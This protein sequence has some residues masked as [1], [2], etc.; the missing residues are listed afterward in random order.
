MRLGPTVGWRQHTSSTQST[1]PVKSKGFFFLLRCSSSRYLRNAFERSEM[2]PK[3]KKRAATTSWTSDR[4]VP[5]LSYE[6]IRFVRKLMA[7]AVQC[8]LLWLMGI[9]TASFENK[10]NFWKQ[11][12]SNQRVEHSKRTLIPSWSIWLA[13]LFHN[14]PLSASARR[15]C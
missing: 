2:S 12:L 13:C 7:A 5:I 1:Q 15:M 4:A 6:C 9:R 3:V 14:R 11:R 10:S 8:E